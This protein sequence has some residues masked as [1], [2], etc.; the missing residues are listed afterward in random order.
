[1]YIHK[2]NMWAQQRVHPD[3]FGEHGAVARCV[4]KDDEPPINCGF[5]SEWRNERVTHVTQP[6]L[7]SRAA[8]VLDGARCHAHHR[9]AVVERPSHLEDVMGTVEGECIW[10]V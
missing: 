1:M 5:V 4:L 3:A 9:Y 8:E 7:P 10:A 2:L 6:I